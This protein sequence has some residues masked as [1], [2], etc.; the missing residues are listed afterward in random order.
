[1]TNSQIRTAS[2]ADSPQ[3]AV[4]PTQ[5]ARLNLPD[6]TRRQSYGRFD[7]RT[8]PRKYPEGA[9]RT[10]CVFVA[11]TFR[12]SPVRAFANRK[13]P[14]VRRPPAPAGPADSGDG[15]QRR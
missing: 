14:R 13:P 12:V 1:M 6:P 3:Q 2:A 15:N 11:G 10:R 8:E 7:G 9:H 4:K 5:K